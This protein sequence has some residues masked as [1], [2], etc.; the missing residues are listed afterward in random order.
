MSKSEGTAKS[1]GESLRAKETNESNI[2][3]QRENGC[4]ANAN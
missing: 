4:E 2:L 1:I 3:L